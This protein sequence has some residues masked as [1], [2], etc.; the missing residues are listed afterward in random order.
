NGFFLLAP[1]AAEPD[2]ET[3]LYYLPLSYRVGKAVTLATVLSFLVLALYMRIGRSS[4]TK[5]FSACGI[6]TI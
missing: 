1:L 3:V 4:P 2:A 6:R 5:S